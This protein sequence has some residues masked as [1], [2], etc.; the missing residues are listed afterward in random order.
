MKKLRQG[1]A[2]PIVLVGNKADLPDNRRVVSFEEGA[3]AARTLDTVFL[4]T[5]AKTGFH[6]EEV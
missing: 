3:E 2:P 4:E 1:Q 5:S 6:L